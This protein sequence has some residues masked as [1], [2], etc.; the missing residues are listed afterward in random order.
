MKLFL[1]HESLGYEG[2]RVLMVKAPNFESA[3]QQINTEVWGNSKYT[4]DREKIHEIHDTSLVGIIYH[5]NDDDD[6]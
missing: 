2:Y 1:Y 3:F 4:I 6:G 5:H